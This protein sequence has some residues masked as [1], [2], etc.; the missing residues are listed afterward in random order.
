MSRPSLPSLAPALALLLASL[1]AAPFLAVLATW[2]RT[3]LEARRGPL[4]SVGALLPWPDLAV[5]SGARHLRFLSLEEP[6]AAFSEGPASLDMDPAGG[7]MAPPYA[8]W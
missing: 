1:V 4:G 2:Q 5:A 6:A 3:T 7:C 8:V